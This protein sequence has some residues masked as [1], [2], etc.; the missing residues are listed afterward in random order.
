MQRQHPLVWANRPLAQALTGG[1]LDIQS[2]RQI[3]HQ[4][5]HA[6]ASDRDG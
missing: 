3:D 2:I 5:E 1:G 6:G 4:P